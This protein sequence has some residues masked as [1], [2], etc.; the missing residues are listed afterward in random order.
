MINLSISG[1]DCILQAH[2]DSPSVSEV[3]VTAV[4][5][6]LMKKQGEH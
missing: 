1:P 3:F 5:P 4:L 2:C 6:A